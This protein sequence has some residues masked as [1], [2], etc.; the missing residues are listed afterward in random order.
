[1]DVQCRLGSK[2]EVT[3]R[4]DDGPLYPQK[5]DMAFG[6]YEYTRKQTGQLFWSRKCR[7]PAFTYFR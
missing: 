1:M 4:F 3:A 6:I 7:R 5:P 2:P